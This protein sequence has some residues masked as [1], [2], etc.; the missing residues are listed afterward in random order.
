MRIMGLDV[1]NR[2]IGIALSDPLMI[3]AQPCETYFR[4][5]LEADI[6]YLKELAGKN[7]VKVIVCGLPLNMNGTQGEQARVTAAF[8][9]RL[10]VESGLAVKYVD[11]RLTTQAA[12]RTLMEG[13]M[14]RENRK[15]FVDQVAAVQILQTYLDRQSMHGPKSI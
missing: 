7:E 8:A 12:H 4:K 9:D 6:A 15:K 3:T 13:G 1:G 11:E 14:R 10:S 5:S 2:R